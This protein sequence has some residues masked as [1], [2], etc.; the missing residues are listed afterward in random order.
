[1]LFAPDSVRNFPAEPLGSKKREYMGAAWADSSSDL[2]A[3]DMERTGVLLGA[4]DFDLVGVFLGVAFAGVAFFADFA[5]DLGAGDLGA[6][7]LDLEG[8][9][10]GDFEGVFLGVAF[11]AT[12]V[13]ER[14]RDLGDLERLATRVALALAARILLMRS[15]F[16][17]SLLIERSVERSLSLGTVSLVS[18][19][20][21]GVGMLLELKRVSWKIRVI[22]IHV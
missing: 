20:F 13:F 18:S 19:D 9:L 2:G 7:D 1:M 14:A 16:L 21:E 6:G 15:D 17:P 8:V 5:G 10:E 4:G 3:G 11:L 22:H 12:G